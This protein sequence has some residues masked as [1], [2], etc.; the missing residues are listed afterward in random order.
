M[1]LSWKII[2]KVPSACSRVQCSKILRKQ[3]MST[4]DNLHLIIYIQL[5]K[6]PGSL[7]NYINTSKH[8]QD[9]STSPGQQTQQLLSQR[10]RIANCLPFCMLATSMNNHYYWQ[11][12]DGLNTEV[13]AKLKW[14]KTSPAVTWLRVTLTSFK[15]YAVNARCRRWC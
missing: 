8:S 15:K 12:L 2:N 6:L 11:A 10:T 4:R 5:N 7:E 3:A 9:F 13:R 14:L 1:A